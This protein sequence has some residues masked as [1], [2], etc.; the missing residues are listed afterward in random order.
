MLTV[1]HYR[2]ESDFQRMRDFLRQV[3]LLNDRR[4]F[5]WSVVRLDYW[6]WHGIYNLGD[7]TLENDVYLWETGEGQLAAFLN[8]E[9]PGHAFLQVHPAFKTPDLEEQVIVQAEESFQVPSRRGGN[10]LWIWTN[11]E[12]GER[13][14]LLRK[15][16]YVHYAESYEHQ[17]RRDL[18]LPIP[19]PHVQAGYTIRS[20]GNRSELPSRSWAS[21]RAFHSNEPDEKYDGDWRW[22][23]NIQAAPLYRPE[24]DLVA[25][26]PA[27]EVAAFT[28]IWYDEVTGCGEFEPVGTMPEHQRHGLAKALMYEGMQRLKQLGATQCMVTGGSPHANGLYQVVMGPIY[29]LYQPWEKRWEK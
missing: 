21:W 27:G 11:A 18:V 19:K 8:R 22:Y 14:E 1:R 7:G 6:R 9:G 10:G 15:R 24:L 25:I 2:S 5:S 28:T 4:Q 12:D 16:G 13:I 20:L 26:A 3:F 17:W 29:D 23:L